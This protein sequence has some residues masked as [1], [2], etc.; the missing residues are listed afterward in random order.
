MWDHFDRNKISFFNFG[1]GVEMAPGFEE[2]EF[3]Y[4][5][6]RSMINYPISAPLFNNTSKLYATFNMY[7]PDQFRADMFMKEFND[8]WVGEGKT[9]PSAL[10][11]TLPN[12]H[13]AG[14]RPNDG[15]PF[16]PSYQA[17]ND[18]ALGR[19]VEFLSHT[20][21]WK[22]MLIVVTEDDSQGGVDHIDAHRS[23]LMLIS[24]YAKKD[25]VG[26]VHYSFGSIFK[27][28][29]NILGIPYI[30]QFDAGATDMSDLFADVPDYT[31]YNA[32][33]SDLRLFDPQ[34]A[35]TPLDAKFNWKALKSAPQMDD[36]EEMERNSHKEDLKKQEER[37][38]AERKNEK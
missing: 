32:L 27:T 35:L 20:P 37:R 16:E 5:G 21:Y 1:M 26:H 30:N 38:N 7:I 19:I 13:G 34:K 36:P 33:P 22:N 2:K 11:L 23:V 29:W 4:S 8:R 28:F 12:D 25:Y 6:T 31:P 9:L 18:L 14:E 15:Y 24:P 3:K 10:T 17:D